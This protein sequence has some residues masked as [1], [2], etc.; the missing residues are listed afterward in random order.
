M[1]VLMYGSETMIWKEER[2]GIRV[3][4]MDNLNGVLDIRRMNTVPNSQMR[5]LCKKKSDER[6]MKVFSDGSAM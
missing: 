1:P 2:T 6:F 5:E 4:Q 3:V